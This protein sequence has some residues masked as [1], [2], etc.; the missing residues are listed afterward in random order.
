MYTTPRQE[1]RKLAETSAHSGRERAPGGSLSG[2]S[3]KRLAGDV[4][5]IC[6]EDGTAERTSIAVA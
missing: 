6:V 3:T 5:T 1:T 2:C 4:L